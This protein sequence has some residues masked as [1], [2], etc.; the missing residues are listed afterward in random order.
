MS[1][2]NSKT[3]IN[4]K[5]CYSATLQEMD[6]SAS[7]ETTAEDLFETELKKKVFVNVP[8]NFQEKDALKQKCR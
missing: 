1:S 5:K 8:I 7:L 3:V 2:D 4:K 6:V